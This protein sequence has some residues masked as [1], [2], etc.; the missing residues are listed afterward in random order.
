MDPTF[1]WSLCCSACVILIS[2]GPLTYA[3]VKAGYSVD[4]MGAPRALFDQL[5]EFGKRAVW[6]H[7]NCWESFTFHAPACILCLLVGAVSPLTVV[8]AW[9]HPL[10]RVIYIC[11]YVGDI[12]TARGLC[13]AIGIISSGLLYKAGLDTLLTY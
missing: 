6:C 12:P 10:V 3:R 13:W 8:A 9:I 7:Q 5:P 2:I 4:N 1:A 11:V